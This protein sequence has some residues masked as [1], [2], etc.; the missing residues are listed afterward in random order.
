MTSIMLTQP[1]KTKALRCLHSLKDSPLK[2]FNPAFFVTIT[3]LKSRHKIK[4]YLNAMDNLSKHPEG[5]NDPD[6]HNIGCGM[7]QE[8]NQNTLS[9][10]SVKN[11][12][13]VLLMK[14]KKKGAPPC[15]VPRAFPNSVDVNFPSAVPTKYFICCTSEACVLSSLATR[16]TSLLRHS[17]KNCTNTVTQ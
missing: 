15:A 17:L 5:S 6:K 11:G 14:K 7:T 1:V 3:G 2:L 16:F 9:R 12:H 13:I 10:E 4:H 8:W